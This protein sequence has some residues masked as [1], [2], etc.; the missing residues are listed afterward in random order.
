MA[1]MKRYATVD[2]FVKTREVWKAEIIKLRKVVLSTGMDEAMKWSFPCYMHGARNVV[3]LGGFKSYFGLWFFDGNLLSDPDKIL[4]NAQQGK[5]K[6]M[7][8]WR[9]TSASQI[10]VRKIKSYLAEAMSVAQDNVTPK[11]APKKKATPKTIAVPPE[12]EGALKSDSKAARAFGKLTPGRQKDYAEY[13]SNAKRAETKVKRL[14]KILPMI[15][16]GVGL[17]DKYRK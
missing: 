14:A 17:N 11:K 7:R 4:T 9:M 5:T 3:G 12:L 1:K 10:K 15:K 8:Q 6:S 2:E 16:Q 13:I